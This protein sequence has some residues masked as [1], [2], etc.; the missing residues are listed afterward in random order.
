MTINLD[1][2]MEAIRKLAEI[3]YKATMRSIRHQQ[4]KFEAGLCS[5]GGCHQKREVKKDGSLARMCR[6]HLDQAN[7]AKAGANG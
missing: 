2:G 1:D 7:P 6:K 3:R 5:Y 4:A